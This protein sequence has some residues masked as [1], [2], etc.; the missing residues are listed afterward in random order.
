MKFSFVPKRGL[1]KQQLLKRSEDANVYALGSHAP[2]FSDKVLNVD[3]C[4][5]QTEP[6]NNVM[7]FGS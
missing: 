2:G 5:L 1:P 6:T 3:K 7:Y 4:F